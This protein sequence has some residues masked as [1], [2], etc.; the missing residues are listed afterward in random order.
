M[1]MFRTV[2][3]S[4]TP[5]AVSFVYA[6]T[7]GIAHGTTPEVWAAHQKEVVAACAAASNLRH[8]KPA[9]K[10]LSNCGLRPRQ[11]RPIDLVSFGPAST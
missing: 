6:A 3:L 2:H 10:R 11:D 1:E 7:V 8:A 4:L 9:G 5:I